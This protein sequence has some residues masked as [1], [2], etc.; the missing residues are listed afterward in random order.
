MASSWFRNLFKLL[1]SGA[2]IASI[3]FAFVVLSPS[4]SSEISEAQADITDFFPRQLLQHRDFDRVMEDLGFEPRPYDYNGNIV[5]FAFADT[6][7]SPQ[8]FS[9]AVQQRLLEAGI[10]S[11]IY[12]TPAY[13]NASS[14]EAIARHKFSEPSMVRSRAMLNGE[15]VPIH[16]TPDH[17]TLAGVVPQKGFN[18]TEELLEMIERRPRHSPLTIDNY[19]DTFR[20]IDARRDPN[21]GGSSVT[22]TWADSNFDPRRI[23]DPSSLDVRLDTEVPSCIGCTRSNRVAALDPDEPYVLNQFETTSSPDRV[24]DFYIQA[25]GQRGWELAQSNKILFELEAHIPELRT[26]GRDL[27]T[28]ERDGEFLNF[29]LSEDPQ[30]RRT[31]IMAIRGQ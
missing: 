11:D 18:S 10:N 2:L 15:M 22:A 27:L 24:R 30:T 17:V 1:L 25:M 14:M 4:P 28:F 29:Y 5:Q 31:N 9:R 6:P 3:G 7:L 13:I 21:T 26:P 12:T 20:F 23:S 19:M 16:S 8:D